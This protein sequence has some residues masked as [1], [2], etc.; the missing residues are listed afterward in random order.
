MKLVIK[1]KEDYNSLF[2]T[3]LKDY[4]I[5]LINDYYSPTK[6]SRLS[7][8]L[9]LDIL[10]IFIYTIN[11]MNISAYGN[12]WTIETDKSLR[13]KE[14]NLD[15]LINFITYGNLKVKGYR[16]LYIILEYVANNIDL[17]YEEWK[18]GC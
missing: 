1:S 15:K 4:M 9:G 2:I 16:L 6:A 11:N 18:D 17:I 5:K 12:A 8:E 10:D 14:Y 13:Y 3:Y 7:F